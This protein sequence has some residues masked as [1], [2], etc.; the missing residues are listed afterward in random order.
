MNSSHP[1]E[2]L[3]EYV[4]AT[5]SHDDMALVD[6]H[7]RT[8]VQCYQTAESYREELFRP[9][10]PRPRLQVK[11]QLFDIV[12]FDR[13]FGSVVRTARVVDAIRWVLAIFLFIV[14]SAFASTFLWNGYDARTQMSLASEKTPQIVADSNDHIAA[15]MAREGMV[16]LRFNRD[17]ALLQGTLLGYVHPKTQGVLF[18]GRDIPRASPSAQYVAWLKG[19]EQVVRIGTLDTDESGV[20]WLYNP[21]ITWCDGCT[22]E[23]SHE[24]SADEMIPVGPRLFYLVYSK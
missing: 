17:S 2:L 12:A 22:V 24:F 1:T 20:V 21:K 16:T 18:V 9:T 7:V 19:N 15:F 11:K 3:L 10:A 8:C 14:G 13:D 6:A 4:L 23:V 5:L